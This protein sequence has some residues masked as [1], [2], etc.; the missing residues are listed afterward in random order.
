MVEITMGF[1]LFNRNERK[2]KMEVKIVVV[3]CMLV[4]LAAFVGG[5]LLGTIHRKK[6]DG[7]TI[8]F[9]P[10]EDGPKCTFKLNYDT[11]EF[12]QKLYVVFKVVHTN[13]S[14]DNGIS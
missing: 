9:S 6:L 12:M 5:Y 11:E 14:S 13:N 2:F 3:L 1:F 7:G 4:F 8:I 10:G